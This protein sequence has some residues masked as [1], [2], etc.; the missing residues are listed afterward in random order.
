M[1]DK[2]IR[3]GIEIV[4]VNAVYDSPQGIAPCAHKAV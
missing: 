1:G 4:V 2:L 3:L